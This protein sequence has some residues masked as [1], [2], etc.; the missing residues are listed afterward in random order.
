MTSARTRAEAV[1]GAAAPAGEKR[2]SLSVQYAVDDDGLPARAR[3]RRWLRACEAGA[4]LVT[5]R[6]VDEAEGRSLNARYRGKDYAT[7]VLSFPYT[8][9]PALAGDLVV[10]VGV[11]RR[12]AQEQGK[13]LEAHFAHLIVHGMLHLLG[14]DHENDADAALMEA[15]EK[16][17]MV[18]LGFPDPYGDN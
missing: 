5:V 10:C 16:Q 4:A 3:V 8:P 11:V 14:F 15:R 2:L 9:A 1:R 6:F 17:V 7:N 13:T 12:E 18:R